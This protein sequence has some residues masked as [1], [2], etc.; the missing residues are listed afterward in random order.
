MVMEILETAQA[1]AQFVA[2]FNYLATVTE[3]AMA[4]DSISSGY[5]W[6]PIDDTQ[7]ANWGVINNAQTPGWETIDDT[8]APNWQNINM[9]S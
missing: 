2:S 1:A 6:N 8:Q 5:L 3:A 7:N 9:N 4:G